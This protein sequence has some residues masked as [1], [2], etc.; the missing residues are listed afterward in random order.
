M[1]KWVDLVVQ[2]NHTSTF[3]DYNSKLRVDITASKDC[4]MSLYLR[5]I[6]PVTLDEA[7]MY[8]HEQLREGRLT[9]RAIREDVIHMI[10]NLEAIAVL[11]KFRITQYYDDQYRF[12]ER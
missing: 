5:E 3:E 1:P 7:E 9:R 2:A 8:V 6:K 4:V 12:R 10:G 11:E